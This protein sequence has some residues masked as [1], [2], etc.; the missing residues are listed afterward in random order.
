[1]DPKPANPTASSPKPAGDARRSESLAVHRAWGKRKWVVWG[2]LAAL[3]VATGVVWHGSQRSPAGPADGTSIGWDINPR[4]GPTATFR[5]A[6]FNIHGCKGLDGRRDPTRIAQCL[7]GLDLV[8]LNEVHGH[9]YASPP[10]QA[11]D[12]GRRLGLGWLF[13]PAEARWWGIDRFGNGLLTALPVRSWQ[14]IPLVRCYDHSC[15]N[16]LLATAE[17]PGGT[18]RVL[19]TH[20]VAGEDRERQGQLRAVIALFESLA[21]PA[22]LLG[23]LNS[24]GDDPHLGQLLARPGIAD[25]LG[26]RR[27]SPGRP[28]IDWILTRGLR[29]VDAGSLD[30]GASDHPMF[31]AELAV[32]GPPERLQ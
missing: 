16:V 7:Q 20:L 18:V 29:T 12:L 15:R 14:R 26:K 9:R 2:I 3:C 25:P 8:A 28:R 22:L 4:T 31:W 24:A 23:D 6:T 1:M 10:D 5:V 32:Q 11:E 30:S 19:V 21:E 13:A 17:C 27:G